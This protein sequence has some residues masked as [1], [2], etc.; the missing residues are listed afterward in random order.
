MQFQQTNYLKP[1]IDKCIEERKNSKFD[2]Y[3][4]IFKGA[5]NFIYGKS[6]ES[7]KNYVNCE[8]ILNSERAKKVIS[9]K[10]FE[11]FTILNKNCI[12]AFKK[13]PQIYLGKP[14]YI[15]FSVLEFSKFFMYSQFYEEIRPKLK[16]PI[17]LMSDTDSFCL[18]AKKDGKGSILDKLDNIIDYSSYPLDHKKFSKTNKNKLDYWKDELKSKQLTH[19]AG[20]RSK[21]YSFLIDDKILKSKAKGVTKSYK[22][23]LVFANYKKCLETI[24]SQ[25]V[26]QY[27]IR[28][29]SHVIRTIQVKKLAYSSFDDKRHLLCSIHSCPYGSKL[30]RKKYCFYCKRDGNDILRV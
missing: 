29:K 20:I 11:N 4:T 19:F 6:I 3:K 23:N 13:K 14:I 5:M 15:G 18:I 7:A 22:K 21:T 9:S 17:V 28:S 8:L 30:I 10:T 16:N 1:Y 2:Y 24:S 26:T 12:L 25:Y 27:H